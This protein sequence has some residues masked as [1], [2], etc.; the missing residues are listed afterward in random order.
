MNA[1]NQ[2]DLVNKQFYWISFSG[3]ER[4]IGRWCDEG[5]TPH[6]EVIGSD[7]FCRFWEVDVLGEVCPTLITH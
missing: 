2:Q 4:T 3:T 6:F 7:E 5:A 1:I